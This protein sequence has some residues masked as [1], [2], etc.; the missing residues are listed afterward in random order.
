[1]NKKIAWITEDCF[2]DT[3]FQV[4]S[5]LS[6]Y[7]DIQWMVVLRPNSHFIENDLKEKHLFLRVFY[8]NRRYRSLRT[9]FLYLKIIQFIK[10]RKADVI[11][12]DMLGLPYFFILV[13]LFLPVKK[14][15]YVAHD[16]EEH[17]GIKGRRL[18]R[19]YQKFIFENFSNFHVFSET[20]HGIFKNRYPHKNV[21]VAHQFLKDFGIADVKPIDNVITFLFFGSIRENKALYLLIEAGNC[22]AKNYAGK[23][24][25]V[26]AGRS[27][28]WKYY[29]AMI[30]QK[31]VFELDI[32]RIPNEEIPIY[33]LS[34]HYLVLPYLDVTQS[35][36]LLIAYNYN[37]PAIASCLEGFKEYI[38]DKKTGYLF[39]TENVD[40]LKEV[41]E[42]V[43]INHEK[44][45]SELK[46][47]LAYFVKENISII[48]I[49]KK[50]I[51]FFDSIANDKK[52]E[53]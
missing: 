24:K 36:P 15:V 8:M 40:S 4:V 10:E 14:V 43:I 44:N 45:Y 39:E 38:E 11:Y 5:E 9:I 27:D 50:Y 41:M 19:I 25:I 6:K 34:S 33:F 21:M 29:D 32:R 52:Q 1:M 3:D 46:S 12:V 42:N 31:N 23:F 13:K 18:M 28:N 22:L 16:V 37:I 48:T 47:N 7:L 49:I 30:Q 17:V 20:Q 26:I 51:K 53:N 2:L 35:G